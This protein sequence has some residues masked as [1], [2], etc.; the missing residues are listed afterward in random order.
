MANFT[1][2]KHSVQKIFMKMCLVMV[3]IIMFRQQD[4]QLHYTNLLRT[5]KWLDCFNHN[6]KVTSLV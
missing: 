2:E 6:F 5:S 1:A 4:R 3:T